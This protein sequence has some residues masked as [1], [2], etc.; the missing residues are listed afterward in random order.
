MIITKTTHN[1]IRYYLK[2][3]KC[4]IEKISKYKANTKT[5][6]CHKCFLE[7]GIARKGTS[8]KSLKNEKNKYFSHTKKEF[9]NCERCG[10]EINS[11][12]GS[13][14]CHTCKVV[15]RNKK[16]NKSSFY[17]GVCY[18][19]KN[20]SFRGTI[21]YNKKLI[22]SLNGRKNDKDTSKTQELKIAI[23]RDRFIIDNNLPHRRN[24][25]DEQLKKHLEYFKLLLF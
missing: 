4:G 6:F 8:D 21:I 9:K 12:I 7:S 5:E 11:I 18:N 24:F 13:K 3:V 20:E 16:K 19:E 2:C 23:I 25:T 17:I 1:P 22:F 14:Y 10:K 15:M